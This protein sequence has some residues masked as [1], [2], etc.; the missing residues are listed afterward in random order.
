MSFQ[1]TRWSVVVAAGEESRSAL[2]ELIE[3]YW[4]PLYAFTRH[5]GAGAHA[6]EDLVQGFFTALIEKGHLR[7]ADRGRGR[8]RTFL[9]AALRH[10]R[11]LPL[12]D[13]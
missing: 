2:S 7:A 1:P 8:F 3:V 13:L 11:A 12:G 5:T 10:H 4:Y 9:L 6:A